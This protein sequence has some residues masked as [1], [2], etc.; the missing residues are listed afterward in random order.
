MEGLTHETLLQ[1]TLKYL[2]SYSKQAYMQIPILSLILVPGPKGESLV[3]M[4]L[5]FR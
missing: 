4:T 2:L 5:K 1:N 3:A